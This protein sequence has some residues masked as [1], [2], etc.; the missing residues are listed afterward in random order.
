MDEELLTTLE[1]SRMLRVQPG[2]VSRWAKQGKIKAV[3]VGTDWR[4]T[5]A[6]VEQFIKDST[7]DPEPPKKVE[8]LAIISY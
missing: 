7:P 3:K 2:S 1:V 8:G 6:A 4:F 5:R